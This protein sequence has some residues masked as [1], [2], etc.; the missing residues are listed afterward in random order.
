M[1]RADC[2]VVAL[3]AV[4]EITYALAEEIAAE[5][6]RAPGRR[7]NSARIIEAA[8]RRGFVF[9]KVRFTGTLYRFM[10]RHPV[11]TFYLNKRGH[12]FALVDGAVV[13]PNGQVRGYGVQV[14]AAW[15]RGQA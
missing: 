1:S 11:G 2:T 7:A 8:K 3:A 9:R 5:G 14:L 4:A 10:Q 13:D 12:A 6:G 15:Q